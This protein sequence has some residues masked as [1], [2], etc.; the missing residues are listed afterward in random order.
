M[1]LLMALFV[2]SPSKTPPISQRYPQF[3]LK[4]FTATQAFKPLSSPVKSTTLSPP[5]SSA[6]SQRSNR[7]SALGS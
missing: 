2:T 4:V 1:A 5:P 6:L 3:S 7:S